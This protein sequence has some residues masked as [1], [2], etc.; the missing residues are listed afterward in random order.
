M[1]EETI[2][3]DY[4]SVADWF[5]ARAA[6]DDFERSV[7]TLASWHVD[8]ELLLSAGMVVMTSA[9]P[10]SKD[11]LLVVFERLDDV[12]NPTVQFQMAVALF[13]RGIRPPK[14]MRM[15]E[16]CVLLDM[17]VGAVAQF[18]LNYSVH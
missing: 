7:N 9:F 14:V 1:Q 4:D 2:R 18:L 13:R 10:F 3:R 15:M 8:D 6:I 16:E 5:A 12:L 11:D 17:E